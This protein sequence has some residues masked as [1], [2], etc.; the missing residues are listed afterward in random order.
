MLADSHLAD[1]PFVVEVDSILLGLVRFGVKLDETDVIEV[2][3]AFDD[4][5][6]LDKLLH[7][8]VIVPP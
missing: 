8:H 4:W 6:A 5:N 2:G 3:A 1:L 7:Y